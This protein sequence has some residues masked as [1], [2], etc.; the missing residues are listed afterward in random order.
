MKAFEVFINGHRLSLIGVGDAGVLTAIVNWVGRPDPERDLFL[1]LGGLDRHSNEHLRWNVPSISV[2][3]EVLVRVVEA[4]VVDP[5][6]SRY[7]SEKQDRVG[8]IE[9]SCASA[10]DCLRPKSGKNC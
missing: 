10:A 8:N 7:R 1:S 5:P 4:P 3:A 6:D 2:G 9:S